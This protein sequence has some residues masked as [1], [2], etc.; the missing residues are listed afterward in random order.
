MTVNAQPYLDFAPLAVRPG[1]RVFVLTGAGISAESGIRTFR[2]AG[3]L[4]ENHRVEDVA[5]PDGW[6]R[7]PELVWRF[8]SERRAQCEPC[9]PNAAHRAL[10]A[11]EAKIGDHL[12]VCTQNIDPL[13]ELAGS[14]RTVHMHG[15]LFR[16]RCS[17]CDRASFADHGVYGTLAEIPR[18]DCGA[19]I[20]PHIVWFGEEPFLMNRIDEALAACTLFVTVGSSGVVFP[21]AGF[22]AFIHARRREAGVRS[23]Y[24][25]PEP[26]ANAAMFDECRLGLAGEALGRLFAVEASH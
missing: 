23:I 21:A 5:S 25:G 20:R 13:H 10:A 19:L 4:W 26:P 7:D 6:R 14:T 3:G 17:S 9:Q 12:F 22:V 8:Y 11:L 15:E 16:S 2:D 1:D 24:V 18:C